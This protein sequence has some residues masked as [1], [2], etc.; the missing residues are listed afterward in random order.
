SKQTKF[1]NT[2]RLKSNIG[3]LGWI[4]S[5]NELSLHSPQKLEHLGYVLNAQEINI[6]ILG[7]KL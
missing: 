6:K 5:E 7:T 3:S 1:D 4:V 2:Q